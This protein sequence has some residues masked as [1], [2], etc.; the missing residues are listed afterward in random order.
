EAESHLNLIP[1]V[2]TPITALGSAHRPRRRL[3]ARRASSTTPAQDTLT[4]MLGRQVKAMVRPAVKAPDG[5]ASGDKPLA[6]P[7][8]PHAGDSPGEFSTSLEVHAR[9]VVQV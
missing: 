4:G 3:V 5:V 8:R 7:A 9:Q 2:A 1:T 6:R